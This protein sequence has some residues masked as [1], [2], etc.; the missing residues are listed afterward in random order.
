MSELENEFNASIVDEKAT[1]VGPAG[2]DIA[3]QRLGNPDVP[4]SGWK[5][6]LLESRY[7]ASRAGDYIAAWRACWRKY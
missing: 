2:I 4:G 1:K 7:R 3:Y 5:A 6:A